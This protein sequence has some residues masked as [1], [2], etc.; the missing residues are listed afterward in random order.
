MTLVESIPM[1]GGQ[2]FAFIVGCIFGSFYNVV[3][4]RLPLGQSIVRPA[5]KCPACGQPI[6]AY[7]NIPLAGY[8]LLGGKC[9]RCKASISPRYPL[10]EA[11]SGLLALLLFRRYGLHAQFPIEFIFCSVLLIVAMIDLDTGLIPDILSLPGIAVGFIFSFLT[12]RLSWSDSLFGILLGGGIFYLIAA[13]YSLIRRKEGLGGG[14]IKLLAMIGAFIGWRGVAFTILA[15]SVSGMIIAVPLMWRH[16]KDLGSS[17][18]FGPFLAFGAV[19]YIFWG[20]LFYHWYF[21]D[22]LGM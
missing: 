9:R 15:S 16:G 17:L 1:L 18:P 5:S 6:A 13:G 4:Y 22:L 3:I 20:E 10:V 11:L 21:S 2:I 12:P 19:S 8:L 7:D 14:D